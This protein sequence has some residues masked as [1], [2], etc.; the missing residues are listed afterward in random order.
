MT[1]YYRTISGVATAKRLE[2]MVI[3]MGFTIGVLKY[4]KM[5]RGGSGIV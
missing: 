5:K 3:G 1:S 4:V 2:E